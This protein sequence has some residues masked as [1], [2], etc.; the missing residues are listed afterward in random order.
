M[1]TLVV[2]LPLG[3]DV[4]CLLIRRHK[5]FRTVAARVL[6]ALSLELSI[7]AFAARGLAAL[8]LE[9]STWAFAARGL[10]ELGLEITGWTFRTGR[11]ARERSIGTVVTFLTRTPTI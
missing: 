10:A 4:T 7:W 3:T 1:S 11:R 2:V 6:P 9:L 8:G 5:S